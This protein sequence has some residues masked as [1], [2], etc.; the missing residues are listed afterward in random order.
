MRV[1]GID[2][3]TGRMGWAVIEKSGGKERLLACDCLETPANTPLSVRLQKIFETLNEVVTTYRPDSAAV[4]DLFFAKNVKTAMSVGH[5]RGV[6]LLCLQL[7]SVPAFDYKPSQ[8]KQAVTGVGNADKL[9]VQ[10]MV[11]AILGMS[12]I[13]KP[14]DAADA[15]AI[16]L[17]HLAMARFR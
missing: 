16:A 10:R 6:I 11:K 5:A 3:G 7:A 12:V 9:Q 15:V 8:I 17:T 1:I 4:E 13:I 2:P 14:D